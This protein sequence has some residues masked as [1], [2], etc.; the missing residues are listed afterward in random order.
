M[1]K[2]NSTDQYLCISDNKTQRKESSSAELR[3]ISMHD[4]RNQVALVDRVA[5]KGVSVVSTTFPMSLRLCYTPS[6]TTIR[7][8]CP[9]TGAETGDSICQEWYQLSIQG[10]Y[11]AHLHSTEN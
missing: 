7:L 2:R 10:S 1:Y 8:T 5:W 3:L 11:K 9:E 4:F 6:C